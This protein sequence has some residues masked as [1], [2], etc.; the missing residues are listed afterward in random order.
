[1]S[2]SSVLKQHSWQMEVTSSLGLTYL[3]PP[4]ADEGLQIG[5]GEDG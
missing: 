1:M 5:E 4:P 2:A 3:I